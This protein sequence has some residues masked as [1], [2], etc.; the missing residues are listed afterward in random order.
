MG[1]NY[2]Q[3]RRIAIKRTRR[4]KEKKQLELQLEEFKDERKIGYAKFKEQPENAMR[5]RVW[6]GATTHHMVLVLYSYGA[7]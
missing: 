3:D 4:P 2:T 5:A 1:L 7:I 6:L